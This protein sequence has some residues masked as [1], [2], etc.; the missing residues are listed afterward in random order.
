MDVKKA[1]DHLSRTQLAQRMF[2]LGIDNDLIEWTQ[3]FLTDR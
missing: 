3:S 2:D 1:F